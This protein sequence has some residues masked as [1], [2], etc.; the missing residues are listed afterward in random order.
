MANPVAWFEITGKDGGALQRFYADVFGWDYQQAPGDGNYGM[1]SAA[2]GGI[3][4]GIG[5]AQDGRGH[6]TVCRTW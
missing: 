2:N 1:V 6:V 5:D 3:G 4:G